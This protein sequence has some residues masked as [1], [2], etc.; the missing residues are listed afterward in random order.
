MSKS[1][2]A[3]DKLGTGVI[4]GVGFILG[5]CLIAFVWGFVGAFM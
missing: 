4:Y 1:K 3:L 5:M 2:E